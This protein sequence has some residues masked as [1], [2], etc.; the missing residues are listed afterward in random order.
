[1][2]PLKRCLETN[3]IFNSSYQSL[4]LECFWLTE[5]DIPR[6]EGCAKS[7]DLFIH[8]PI[9]DN[10]KGIYQLSTRYL[11]SLLRPE[12][13]AISIPVSYFAGYNPEMIYLKDKAGSNVDGPFM[14]HDKNILKLY[15][16]GKSISETVDTLYQGNIYP[17]D[18]V[19]V[20]LDA[21]IAE[22][23]QREA[24]LDI[25]IADFIQHNY[26]TSRLFHTINHPGVSVIAQITKAI[27]NL[28]EIPLDLPSLDAFCQHE[29]LDAVYFPI[30]PS[31]AQSLGLNFPLEPNYYFHQFVHPQDAIAHFFSFYDQNSDIVE[32][33]LSRFIGFSKSN[34]ATEANL[35]NCYRLVLRREP[36]AD[37]KIFWM[38]QISS[39]MLSLEWLVREFIHSDEFQAHQRDR[40]SSPVTDDNFD[41]L[42]DHYC[43][44]VRQN[45]GV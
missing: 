18:Y 5:D 4:Q 24:N 23:R 26:H 25:K 35:D 41:Q 33:N 19:L 11:R 44:L 9:S 6:L 21:T 20:N 29:V 14:Y 17:P 22:L 27:L 7:I 28:L 10:Y 3:P 42:V 39:Q 30:Y 31:V 45:S 2:E 13:R 36:D 1:V 43:A 15:A 8:Q 32:Y 34:T 38:Q 37:G 16:Q 12:A 40:N